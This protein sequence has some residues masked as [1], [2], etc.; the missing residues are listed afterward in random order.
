RTL[1]SSPGA[2]PRLETSVMIVG[3]FEL[4]MA[5]RAGAGD[6]D[7]RPPAAVAEGRVSPCRGVTHAPAAPFVPP[8]GRAGDRGR[9]PAGARVTRGRA[10][11]GHAAVDRP[12]RRL[13][14]AER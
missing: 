4:L 6:A 2:G 14:A 7:H 13:S 1:R 5:W 9:P 8:G 3:S 12:G 11:G 10:Y